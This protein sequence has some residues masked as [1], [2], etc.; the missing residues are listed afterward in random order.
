MFETYLK[1]IVL[2]KMFKSDTAK[3]AVTNHH[4]QESNMGEYEGEK[5]PDCNQA[6]WEGAYTWMFRKCSSSSPLWSGILT[7]W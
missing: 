6:F 1:L 7:I 3:D 4:G 5:A 2:F